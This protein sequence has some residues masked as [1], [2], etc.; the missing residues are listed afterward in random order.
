MMPAQIVTAA[1]AV[2]SNPSPKAA[3]LFDQ[4]VAAHLVQIVIHRNFPDRLVGCAVSG[5]SFERACIVSNHLA[6]PRG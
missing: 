5:R 6:F 1:V 2:S 4:P 3:H